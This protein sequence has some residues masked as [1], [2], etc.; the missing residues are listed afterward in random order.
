MA[1]SSRAGKREMA[2]AS[3]ARPCSEVS[4]FLR[5]SSVSSV[6]SLGLL[7]A[8]K[9]FNTENTEEYR[10]EQIRESDPRKRP[11]GALPIKSDRLSTV[12][13]QH[14]SCEMRYHRGVSQTF[15]SEA[16]TREIRVRVQAEYDPSRSSPYHSQWFFLYTVNITN[17]SQD[18]VQLISRH[19]IITDGIGKVQEVQG[20]GVIGKQPKLAPGQSF[21]YTS[22]CPLTTP[23]GAMHG[24]YQMVNQTGEKFD[25]EIAPF[26]ADGALHH[27]Q[28]G[29]PRHPL[30]LRLRP[31]SPRLPCPAA[32]KTPATVRRSRPP[33]AQILTAGRSFPVA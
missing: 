26:Y 14:E 13:G 10:E 30:R 15:S 20:P 7:E 28:L 11:S 23:F 29:T 8:E 6:L 5:L 2:N 24:T 4:S 9:P 25:I 27:R 12:A 17:E 21:E 16:T 1:H 3:R 19:W 18:T 33:E 22:G 31:P 32:R